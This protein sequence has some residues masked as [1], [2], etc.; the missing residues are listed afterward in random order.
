L[1]AC[2]WRAV[3][4]TR[5]REM[6]IE[7]GEIT[8]KVQHATRKLYHWSRVSLHLCFTIRFGQTTAITLFR[9]HAKNG[10]FYDAFSVLYEQRNLFIAETQ[11]SRNFYSVACLYTYVTCPL[12]NENLL[13]WKRQ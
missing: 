7:E 10:V 13:I 6:W 3:Y 4:A 1:P 5:L 8:K 11:L 9:E 12:M 2:A